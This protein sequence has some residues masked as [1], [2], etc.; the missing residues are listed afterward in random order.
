MVERVGQC[1]AI[2]C[3]GG[4]VQWGPAPPEPTKAELGAAEKA[5]LEEKHAA[6]KQRL[7]EAKVHRREAEAAIQTK[8]AEIKRM[9]V[10][11]AR[12]GPLTRPCA[13]EKISPSPSNSS[14]LP[15]PS[16]TDRASRQTLSWRS[17][18]ATQHPPPI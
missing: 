18:P 10:R 13:A 5:L 3:S 6:N 4:G 16:Q 8:Q 7:Q 17:P 1:I 11:G 15:E 12:G 2:K 14:A 9:E